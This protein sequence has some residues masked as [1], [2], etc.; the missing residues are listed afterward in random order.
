MSVRREQVEQIETDLFLLYIRLAECMRVPSCRNA[1]L[2]LLGHVVRRQPSWLHK[3]TQYPVMKEL[4]KILRQDDN[5]VH[6]T[7]ATLLLVT[8]LPVIPAKMGPFLSEI[9]EVFRYISSNRVISCILAAWPMDI[10]LD[11]GLFS[12]PNRSM[13]ILNF[14]SIFVCLIPF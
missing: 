14:I 6:L 13:G 3:I 4:L 2:D 1:G 8:L 12:V 7:S 9:F 11:D 10:G 5:I